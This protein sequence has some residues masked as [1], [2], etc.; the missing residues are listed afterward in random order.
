MGLDGIRIQEY[1]IRP[2]TTLFDST[3]NKTL[4]KVCVSFCKCHQNY[5]DQMKSKGYH[6][7]LNI[8]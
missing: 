2:E 1:C 3:W 4:R 8:L 5:I 6:I 7:G